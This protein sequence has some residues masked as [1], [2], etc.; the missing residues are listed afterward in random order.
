MRKLLHGVAALLL[1][2]LSGCI[3]HHHHKPA[4]NQSLAPQS[5]ETTQ[6]DNSTAPA[7]APPTPAPAPAATT[8]QPPTQQPAAQPPATAP[9]DKTAHHAIHRKRPEGKPVEM[10]SNATPEVS[11]V[12][13][14][15]PGDPSDLR[16]QTESSLNSIDQTIK[17]LN[18]PL[19]QQEQKTL[20]QIREFLKQA[21]SALASGDVDG[22]HTLALKARVLLDEITH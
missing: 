18:R 2:S 6:A 3:F 14:L 4:P 7:T 8:T 21:R 1:L 15:S 16:V 19:S 17:K 9:P 20:A 11:A 22:A 12:G 10:A 13:Q 5:L